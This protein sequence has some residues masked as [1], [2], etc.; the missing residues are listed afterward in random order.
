MEKPLEI[1]VIWYDTA[2]RIPIRIGIPEDLTAPEAKKAL[3][4][5]VGFLATLAAFP[6][7][8]KLTFGQMPNSQSEKA[9]KPN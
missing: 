7:A 3:E 8:D 4:E 9:G 1:P 5:F 2:G 6:N